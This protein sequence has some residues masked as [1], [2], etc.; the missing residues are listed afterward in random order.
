MLLSSIVCVCVCVCIHW[1][2]LCVCVRAYTLACLCVCVC[3]CVC[4]FIN[5]LICMYTCVHLH[6]DIW[7]GHDRKISK[8]IYICWTLW[9]GSYAHLLH[10]YCKLITKITT[11]TT[12]TAAAAAVL[13]VQITDDM[14]GV[15]GCIII[16]IIVSGP[17]RNK[18][19][20]V[21]SPGILILDQSLQRLPGLSC[22][23]ASASA[24][25]DTKIPPTFSGQLQ[26]LGSL[27]TFSG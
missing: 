22:C 14:A 26:T 12:T 10:K 25:T 17:V 18:S 11:T 4:V 27:P 9:F 20:D 16:I 19:T 3:V 21:S 23:K 24:S 8:C 6:H 1:H 13:R 2:A 7:L 15:Y 5:A